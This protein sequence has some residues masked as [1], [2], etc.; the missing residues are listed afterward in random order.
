[1]H[2]N[3]NVFNFFQGDGAMAWHGKIL[4]GLFLLLFSFV[5]LSEVTAKA[6][7]EYIFYVGYHNKC[8]MY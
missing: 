2:L 1:M 4:P 7:G 5:V 6:V 8:V 3:T